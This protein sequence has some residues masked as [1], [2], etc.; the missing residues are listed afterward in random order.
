VAA[1][2][3]ASSQIQDA[4]S[5]VSAFVAQNAEREIGVIQAKLQ[6][7]LAIIDESERAGLLTEKE[8]AKRREQ[9]QKKAA[10]EEAKIRRK[11]AEADKAINIAKVLTQIPLTAF[12]AYSSAQTLPFPASQIVGGILAGIAV[13]TGLA[14]VAQIA[15][16]PLPPIP[17]FSKGV[18][19]L[20]GPGTETSDSI[21][22][23]LSK[24][25][26]VMTAAE[27]KAYFPVLKAIRE[28]KL[29][30][31][32]LNKLVEVAESAKRSDGGEPVTVNV[33]ADS[34]GFTLFVER[35]SEKL[36]VLNER[37]TAKYRRVV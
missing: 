24:G 25:E 28:R 35:N 4:L 2:Q 12:Q 20:Q 14:Q 23:L 7:Q 16:T 36:R 6:K 8:A 1:Y 18:L 11:Q 9:E 31:E 21:P 3:L 34:N 33:N 26:S 10:I 37:Y 22:A 5:A 30:A 27:T 13:A 32:L 19:N 29:P 17:S 15:A